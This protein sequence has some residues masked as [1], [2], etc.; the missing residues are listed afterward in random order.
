MGRK[1]GS[2]NMGSF[3]ETVTQAGDTVL[4]L[5]RR[6]SFKDAIDVAIVTVLLY[7][8]IKLVRDT[9]AGQPWW[10]TPWSLP[11]SWSRA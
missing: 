8:L 7:G 5:A 10:P 9:R 1:R 3:I 11:G 2:K 4:D 6:F